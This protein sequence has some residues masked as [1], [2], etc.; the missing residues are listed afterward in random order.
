MG[1]EMRFVI[2]FIVI[3]NTILLALSSLICRSGT[4]KAV[5]VDSAFYDAP[6]ISTTGVKTGGY[7]Y[8]IDNTTGVVYLEYVNAHGSSISVML[9]PDGTPLMEEDIRKSE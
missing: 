3:F 5:R 4:A 2:L 8:L 1:K 9:K 7:N 6:D